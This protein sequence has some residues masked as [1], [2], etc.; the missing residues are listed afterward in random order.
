MTVKQGILNEMAEVRE[1]CSILFN[2]ADKWLIKHGG[3]RITQDENAPIRILLC[4]AYNTGKS[5]IVNA[6]L[7]EMKAVTGDFPVTKEA[8]EYDWRNYHI[9]D[10]P[11]YDARE[12]EADIARTEVK[13]ADVVLYV[14][15][16]SGLDLDTTWIDIQ[17]LAQDRI[18][19]LVVVNDKQPVQNDEEEKT[20]KEKIQKYYLEKASE[21]LGRDSVHTMHWIRAKRAEKGRK[22]KKDGLIQTSGIEQLE[23]EILQKLADCEVIVKLR[24][25]LADHE[26]AVKTI[27]DKISK[28]LETREDKKLSLLLED[29]SN[30]R[31]QLN[32]KA[33]VISQENLSGLKDLIASFQEGRVVGMA[34]TF[35]L[36]DEIETTYSQAL[37]SFELSSK[38]KMRNV[39]AKINKDII[40]DGIKEDPLKLVF[41]SISEIGSTDGTSGSD[42]AKDG[43]K[44]AL[45]AFA[46]EWAKDSAEETLKQTGKQALKE[47]GKATVKETAKQTGKETVKQGFKQ[48]AK[49]AAKKWLGPA[50]EVIDGLY[51]ATKGWQ[52][53]KEEKKKM[54]IA[55]RQINAHTELLVNRIKQRFITTCSDYINT[56][57]NPIESSIN[58]QLQEKQKDESGIMRQY[59]LGNELLL[60]MENT[61]TK[62][63]AWVQNDNKTL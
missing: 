21:K 51:T 8:H 30:V 47:A 7:G 35:E 2:K 45:K 14:C 53:A 54:E 40:N 33:K 49:E 57:V 15:S 24:K 16:Q 38:E 19:F 18:P 6:L 27:R 34:S 52:K 37:E 41:P 13:K 62:L 59:A 28:E 50:I 1:K 3:K 9:V 25:Q 44:T 58:E 42:M 61:S 31:Q 32:D 63:F 12:M 5:T 36:S 4:G 43:L 48:T 17:G 60:K 22:E 10:L 39:Y 29:C 23:A 26:Q 46:K 20:R 55:M 56:L 11:G